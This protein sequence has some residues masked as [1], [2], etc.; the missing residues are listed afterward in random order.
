MS[1]AQTN[2]IS[3]I[4]T[5]RVI[6]ILL[7]VWGHSY[8]FNVPI[9]GSLDA[10]RSF[11]YTFHMPLFILI[12]GYLAGKSRKSPGE[13][14]ANRA[15]KLLI[16]YFALSLAA[17]LPKML[18]QQYL[19][20]SVEFSLAYLLRTEL[21][22]RENVWG[23]FWFIP[24]IFAFGVFSALMKN[25]LKKRGGGGYWFWQERICCCGCPKPLPG[26]P[27]KICG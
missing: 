13:Y 26:L 6:G 17:F 22:P 20:D 14:I 8:P 18:V 1:G 2:R 15:K 27:W 9:P 23:H 11:V 4:S 12:S 25:Q 5:A 10:V 21:V 3:F 24:V 19:N 16:P 7:V